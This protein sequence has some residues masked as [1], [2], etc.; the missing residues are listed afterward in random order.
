MNILTIIPNRSD[1]TSF[2]RAAGP[3]NYMQR[4]YGIRCATPSRVGWAEITSA[5]VVFI[6]RGYSEQHKTIVEMCNRLNIPVWLDYDD[7]LFCVPKDNPSY[8]LYSNEKTMQTIAEII[9]MSQLVTVSTHQLK[10]NLLKLNE[11]IHVVPNAIDEQIFKQ[12]NPKQRKGIF[13]W[14]GSDT[15]VKDISTYAPELKEVI[16]KDDKW[17]YLFIGH[18][19]WYLGSMPEKRFLYQKPMDIIE[20]FEALKNISPTAMIVPLAENDFNKCKSN[21]AWLEAI[22]SGALAIVPDWPEWKHPGALRY[23]DANEFKFKINKAKKLEDDEIYTRVKSAQK[24]ALDNF[25]LKLTC[26]KRLAL[27]KELKPKPEK[28]D[29]LKNLNHPDYQLDN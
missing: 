26:S 21:I 11:N 9:A 7:D 23:K 3:L 13:T 6:Q 1:A 20:Y 29:L 15:H 4:N 8:D 12:S 14:R 28:S 22:W 27:L 25:S 16:Q 17:I 24:Y 18:R 2:Y 10:V 19:P 5:N